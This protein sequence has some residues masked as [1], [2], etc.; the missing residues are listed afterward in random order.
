MWMGSPPTKPHHTEQPTLIPR[1]EPGLAQKPHSDSGC[2]SWPSHTPGGQRLDSTACTLTSVVCSGDRKLAPTPCLVKVHVQDVP[3]FP[4]PE[5]MRLHGVD[6]DGGGARMGAGLALGK[7]FR[8]RLIRGPP[9][10]PPQAADS[11]PCS[12]AVGTFRL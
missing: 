4:N 6:P 9:P 2:Y 10:R 1:R 11:R 5:G 7:D 3:K 12:D 8:Q